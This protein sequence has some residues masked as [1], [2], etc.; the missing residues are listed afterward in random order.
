MERSTTLGIGL[1]IGSA[2]LLL[3]IYCGFIVRSPTPQGFPPAGPSDEYRPEASTHIYERPS[4][5]LAR[6][7]VFHSFHTLV[8]LSQQRYELSD[9]SAA[10]PEDFPT[11]VGPRDVEYGPNPVIF[12]GAVLPPVRHIAAPI[13]ISES[14]QVPASQISLAG[15]SS[16][17]EPEIGSQIE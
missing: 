14:H 15:P 7:A 8:E 16:S 10:R 2:F 1:S 12:P 4:P 9:T 11:T 3:Y 13:E 17:L 6:A 5:I